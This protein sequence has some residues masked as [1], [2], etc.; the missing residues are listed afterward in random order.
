MNSSLTECYHRP[1]NKQHLMMYRLYHWWFT[2]STNNIGKENNW[3]HNLFINLFFIRLIIIWVWK[4]K[5]EFN[6]L[7]PFIT[8]CWFSRYITL[9]WWTSGVQF[10]RLRTSG[11]WLRCVAST[12]RLRTLTPL[13]SSRPRPALSWSPRKTF[14]WCRQCGREVVWVTRFEVDRGWRI[15]IL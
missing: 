1:I 12:G 15:C 7:K 14:A 3:K 5:R 4:S 11:V 9:A 2:F 13:T 8:Y 10:F 6:I